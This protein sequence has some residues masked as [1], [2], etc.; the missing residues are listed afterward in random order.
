MDTKSGIWFVYVRYQ[1]TW[2][3]S[4]SSLSTVTLYYKG[5]P[6]EIQRGWLVNYFG[7]KVVIQQG[8]TKEIFEMK[9]TF[10][11]LYMKI[12]TPEVSLHWDG[13]GS[14]IVGVSRDTQT[15]GLCG[16]NKVGEQL[17][18]RFRRR[19]NPERNE[20]LVSSVVKSWSLGRSCR[21]EEDLISP[22][23]FGK[24]PE[25]DCETLDTH[26]IPNILVDFYRDSCSKDE[27]RRER[28][29]GSVP[30]Y[31]FT[32][33]AIYQL[34]DNLQGRVQTANKSRDSRVQTDLPSVCSLSV[35]RR[36]YLAYYAGCPNSSPPFTVT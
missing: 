15:L 2:Q 30:T 11:G 32:Q 34:R 17:R 35:L 12:T 18:G 28:M 21:Y 10:D 27:R 8:Q 3:I 5:V 25:Y 22:E 7:T 26:N 9:L 4:T 24:V 6:L 13:V 36:Q 33:L 29:A 16:S 20:V 1:E 23:E 31:C 14:L 19:R